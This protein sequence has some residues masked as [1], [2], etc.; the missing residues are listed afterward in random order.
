ME[1]LD[2]LLAE[3]LIIA[4]RNK[5]GQGSVQ[6]LREIDNTLNQS[7]HNPENWVARRTLH[8]I[9]NNPEVGSLGF[10]QEH[11]HKQSGARRLTRL[12]TEPEF[13]ELEI[14]TGREWCGPLQH[15]VDPPTE[16]EISAIR[17][18]WKPSSLRF[19]WKHLCGH[20]KP[21]A[22]PSV[23]RTPEQLLMELFA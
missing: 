11:I 13:A 15:T 3:A 8:I 20:H 12:E 17:A 10:F 21:P 4:M 23:T 9:H 16:G 7:F 14:V 6:R 18:Y 5:R 22:K 1:E 2:N 19:A